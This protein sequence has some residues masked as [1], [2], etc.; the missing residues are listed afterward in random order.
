MPLSEHERKLLAQLEKQLHEDDPKFANSMESATS[1]S[2][3]ARNLVIFVLSALA[4]VFIL[5]VGVTLPNIFVGVLGFIVMVSGVYYATR[6]S[7]IS[8]AK[9]SKAGKK[10]T[11][12]MRRLGERWDGR[13]RGEP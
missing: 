6:R 11:A 9:G 13:R 2:Q 1:R 12:F 7:G 5:L 8:A 10:R 4:G 3:S